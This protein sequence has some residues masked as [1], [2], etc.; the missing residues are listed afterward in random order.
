MTPVPPEATARVAD[1]LAALPDVFWF[2]VG[3][4]QLDKLPELGVPRAGVT[5][6]GEFDNTTLVVPVLVVTPVPPLA[7]GNVPET[8]VVRLV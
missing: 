6:V 3:N 5:N 2:S 1:R 8:L 4:V 7:T